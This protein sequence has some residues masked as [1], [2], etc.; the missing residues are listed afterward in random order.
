MIFQRVPGEVS[1]KTLVDNVAVVIDRMTA[2]RAAR[3]HG[4]GR[5]ERV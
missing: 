1:P 4:R 2:F 5:G 3:G